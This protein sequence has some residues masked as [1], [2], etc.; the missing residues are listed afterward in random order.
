MMLRMNWWLWQRY[1]SEERIRWNEAD[2]LE[3]GKPSAE[4]ERGTEFGKTEKGVENLGRERNEYW[5]EMW[6][7]EQYG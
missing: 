1:P 3:C 7:M 2:V 4:P 6:C 5:E